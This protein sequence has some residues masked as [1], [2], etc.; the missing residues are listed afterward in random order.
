MKELSVFSLIC[1]CF[2]PEARNKLVVC[3]F[4]GKNQ[5]TR[6]VRTNQDRKVTTDIAGVSS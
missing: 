4:E 6:E 2:Y 5:V 3:E 1:S